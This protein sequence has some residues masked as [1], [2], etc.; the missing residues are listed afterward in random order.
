M[1]VERRAG[2]PGQQEFAQFSNAGTT[3]FSDL[4]TSQGYEALGRCCRMQVMGL[5]LDGANENEMFESMREEAE[6][7]LRMHWP[8]LSDQDCSRKK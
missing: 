8:Q 7:R 2:Q 1:E 4:A 6:S 5:G 3:K